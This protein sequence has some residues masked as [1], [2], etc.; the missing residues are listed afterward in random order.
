MVEISKESFDLPRATRTVAGATKHIPELLPL[1][2]LSKLM[3]S[4]LTSKKQAR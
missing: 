1:V 4:R 3:I 2:L